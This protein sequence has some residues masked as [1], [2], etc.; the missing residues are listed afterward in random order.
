[1]TDSIFSG[2]VLRLAFGGEGII[3]QEGLIIFV[4]FTAPGDRITYRIIR[5]KKNFAFGEL[6]DIQQPS[7]QRISPKCRYFG[8]CGGCQLQH[9]NYAN[10]LDYKRQSIQDALVRQAK[11][12]DI[13]VPPVVPAKQQWSYRRRI[14]L[15]LKPSQ[16]YFLAGYTTADGANLLPVVQCPI[17]VDSDNPLLDQVQAVAKALDSQGNVESKLTLLKR[18][19]ETFLLH[20]HFKILPSN[21]ETVLKEATQ[22]YPN[23]TGV[24]ASS[25][26]KIL[27]FGQLETQFEIGGLSFDFSPKAFIQNHPEQSLNIYQSLCNHAES[28]QPKNVLD[29]YSGIGISSLMLANLGLNITGVESNKDAVRL[30]QINAKKN[31]IGSVNFVQADVQ[32]VLGSLLEKNPD[33]VI[34]NPPREGLDPSVIQALIKQP[35]PAILYISCMPPTLARDL[36][37]LCA[38]KYQV[39][40]IEAYDMFPQTSHVE[41]LTYLKLN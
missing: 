20:F 16:G 21:A 30:A 18:D 33:L 4:P 1:M 8:T 29:L 19:N 26:K 11:L 28:L 37:L 2:E 36:K 31:G 3:H 6:I 34:V 39:G 35:P 32:Q 24:I 15:T 13:V 40:T 22:R 10:Q 27:Q 23:W 14:S 17:F 12:T 38:E 25:P 41:T 5:R 7:V 9:L